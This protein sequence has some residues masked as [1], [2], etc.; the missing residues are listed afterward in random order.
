[1]HACMLYT[2]GFRRSCYAVQHI[3]GWRTTGG[4]LVGG[5]PKP[6]PPN[7]YG[8][9]FS[10]FPSSS[11]IPYTTSMK[12]M[13]RRTP[14]LYLGGLVPDYCSPTFFFGQPLCPEGG[15]RYSRPVSPLSRILQAS[16]MSS[17]ALGFG[18]GFAPRPNAP[19]DR[20]CNSAL[21]A[22]LSNMAAAEGICRGP[23]THQ[24]TE[25]VSRDK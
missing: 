19:S 24:S 23:L 18:L 25:T 22:A 21:A 10:S 11:S 1:M 4:W 8:C 5:P 20:R 9:P 16:C 15:S 14:A 6:I 12:S 17:F 13:K 3:R 7:L 2:A